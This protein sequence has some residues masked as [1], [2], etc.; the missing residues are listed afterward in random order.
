[1]SKKLIWIVITLSF[2]FSILIAFT[3]PVSQGATSRATAQIAPVDDAWRAALPRDPEAATTA[4]MARISPAAKARSDAYFEGGYWLQLVD[5]IVGIAAAVILLRSKV[6]VGFRDWLAAKLRVQ[7]LIDTA[8]AIVYS[9]LI[10]LI[11]FPLMV[12]EGYYREHF[13]GLSNLNAVDWFMENML[14]LSISTIGMGIAIGMLYIA[15]RRTRSSWWIWGAGIA[16]SLIGVLMLL[17][18]TYI[19]PLFNTYKPIAD[20][21]I[22]DPVMAMM[23]AN[24]VPIDNLYQFDASKQSNRVSANVSG[25]FGSAAVRMNDNLLKSSTI[26]EIKAVLGHE[27]GHYTMNHIYKGWMEIGIVLVIGFA[28]VKWALDWSIEKWG[29]ALGIKDYADIA[30]LP[31]FIVWFSVF[32]FIAT[33]INN[34]L[35][36]TQEVEADIFGLNASAEPL[37][38]AEAMLKLTQYR[39][40]NPGDVEELMFFDHPSPRK[41]IYSAMRWRAEQQKP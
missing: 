31:L 13:Y 3:A 12:Y 30:G 33:P 40:S 15:L 32:M 11:T 16:I 2:I 41:R 10:S 19:D 20:A 7:W 34:T 27:L 5:L 18:P 1:M 21:R 26:S 14:M 29:S 36:R 23:R 8:T 24:G 9:C 37:G 4:Y 39:K 35:I 6:L 38:F 17:S 25:I 28:F 22:K